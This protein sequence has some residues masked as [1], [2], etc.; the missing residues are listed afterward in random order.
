MLPFQPGPQNWG[1]IAFAEFCTETNFKGDCQIYRESQRDL[2]VFAQKAV[3][4]NINGTCAWQV[5]TEAQYE[6][7]SVILAPGEFEILDRLLNISTKHHCGNY[8]ST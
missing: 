2:E 5:F 8:V 1:C 7:Q 3:S 4:A 6:G